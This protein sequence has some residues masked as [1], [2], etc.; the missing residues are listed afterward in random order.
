MMTAHAFGLL[1]AIVSNVLFSLLFFYGKLMNPMSG[2]D[3]FAWR[4]FASLPAICLLITLNRCWRSVWK[5]IGDI[6]CH[7]R[8]WLL[9]LAPTPIMAGQLCLFMWAPMHGKGI[10]VAI[11]YFLFPLAMALGGVFIFRERLSSTQK[12][13]ISL[14]AVGVAIEIFKTGSFSWVSLVIFTT[15]PIYYLLR[16]Y[17]GV[18]SLVGLFIDMVVIFPFVLLYLFCFSPSLEQI[19]MQPHLMI[20]IAILG[21]HGAIAMQLNLAANHY[22]PVILFSIM[23]YLEPALLFVISIVF[24]GEALTLSSLLSYG[25]IWAGIVL[26][27]RSNLITLRQERHKQKIEST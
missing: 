11:G 2:V 16:R 10:E 12:L 23:S 17:L 14:A 8:K 22:L 1:A 27:I 13:A 4:M 26:V 20:W 18:P 21:A 3:I 7:W 6:G 5:F 15:Y 19:A 24:L 9:I 25:L